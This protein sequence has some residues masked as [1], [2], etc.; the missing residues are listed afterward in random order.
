V[1]VACARK[2]PSGQ[3]PEGKDSV[4]ESVGAGAGVGAVNGT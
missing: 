4:Q 3:E 1:R 2:E